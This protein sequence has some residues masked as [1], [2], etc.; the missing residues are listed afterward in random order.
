MQTENEWLNI[1]LRWNYIF[2]AIPYRWMAQKT[3]FHLSI[4]IIKKHIMSMT[5]F[6]NLAQSNWQ[7]GNKFKYD[8]QIQHHEGWVKLPVPVRFDADLV[9]LSDD[10]VH[11]HTDREM[12][13][14]AWLSANWV[15]SIIW[16]VWY[17]TTLYQ[18][19]LCPVSFISYQRWPLTGHTS[20]IQLCITDIKKH[21]TNMT[22]DNS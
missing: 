16:T 11:Y 2:W 5:F 21:T 10:I 1:Y 18:R 3:S 9:G 13:N 20:T 12:C 4:G 22:N 7:N 14:I 17:L 15:C 8:P 19:T 6:Y